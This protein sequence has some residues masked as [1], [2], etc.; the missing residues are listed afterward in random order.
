MV[1]GRIAQ[2]AGRNRAAIRGLEI[3][4]EPV[5][6]V[7]MSVLV[8]LSFCCAVAGSHKYSL[9]ITAFND[10]GIYPIVFG[11]RCHCSSKEILQYR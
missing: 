7:N 8:G 10:I 4:V 3:P 9:R 1:V 6:S 5:I 2:P 11:P